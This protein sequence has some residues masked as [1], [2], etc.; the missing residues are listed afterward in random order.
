M[1]FVSASRVKFGPFGA[2]VEWKTIL[3]FVEIVK[4]LEILKLDHSSTVHIKKTE[5][6]VVF[7]VWFLQKVFKIGPVGKCKAAISSTIGNTE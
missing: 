7:G 6:D 1:T 2:P 3:G 4:L 5:G